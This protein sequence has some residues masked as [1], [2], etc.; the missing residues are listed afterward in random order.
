M[1]KEEVV[2]E[3]LQYCLVES[4][5]LRLPFCSST[6]TKI[7]KRSKEVAWLERASAEEPLQVETVK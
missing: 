1:Q 6:F 2:K 4:F 5:T 3:E 7:L